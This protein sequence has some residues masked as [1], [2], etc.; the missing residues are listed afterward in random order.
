MLTATLALYLVAV[1]YETIRIIERP[2]IEEFNREMRLSIGTE[3]PA[4]VWWALLIP[5]AFVKCL[6]L[7][8]VRLW[9]ALS[10]LRFRFKV[11][12]LQRDFIRSL[13]RAGFKGK[14]KVTTEI[15]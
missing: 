12:R 13:R 2:P 3:M 6:P 14:T 1:V 15:R 8:L 4:F 11:W 7:P 10:W 9:A 5:M